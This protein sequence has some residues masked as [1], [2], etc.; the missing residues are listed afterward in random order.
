[1]LKGF[2]EH[3][4]TAC[5][6]NARPLTHSYYQLDARFCVHCWVQ[7]SESLSVW[8]SAL[9]LPLSSLIS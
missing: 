3:R 1:M 8:V 6:K 2:L 5:D 7:R 4:R 9:E